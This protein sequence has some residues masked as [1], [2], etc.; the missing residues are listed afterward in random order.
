MHGP[1]GTNYPNELIFQEI[2]EPNKV[3]IRHDCNPY[4]T[5]TVNIIN[6]EGGSIVEWYQDFDDPEV[7]RK[8]APN[9]EPAN[10][11]LMDKL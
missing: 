6:T 11:L 7:A 2:I 4:F 3:L 8:M 9:V 5:A 10:E 1:N